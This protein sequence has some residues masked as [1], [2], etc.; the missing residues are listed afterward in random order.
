MQ[1]VIAQD[2]E[3]LKAR[4]IEAHRAYLDSLLIWERAR[5]LA[6]CPRCRPRDVSDADLE[7]RCS[8]AEVEHTRR[9]LVFQQLSIELGYVPRLPFCLPKEDETWC[10]RIQAN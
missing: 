10:A 7:R 1:A 2:D 5:H 8:D 9:R 4:T 3:A 6:N